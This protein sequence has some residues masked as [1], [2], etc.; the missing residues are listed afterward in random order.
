MSDIVK[1]LAR[2]P[3]ERREE[4]LALLREELGGGELRLEPRERTGPVPLSFSQ[5]T[6]WFLDR[7][8]PGRPTYNVPFASRIRGPLDVA[9]LGNSLRALV[10]RHESLRTSFREDADGPVQVVEDEVAVELPVVAVPG[11]DPSARLARARE[12]AGEQARGPFDLTRPPLWRARLLRVDDDDHLLLLTVHHIVYDGWSLGVM[13][14]ELAEGY[15]ARVEGTGPVLPALPVQYSDYALWQREWL[16][17]DRLDELTAWW[18]DRLGGAP[19]L[20]L[21]TDRARP[22]RLTFDGRFVRRRVPVEASDALHALARREGVTPFT[23]FVAVFAVLMHR[24]SG[25]D[26]VVIGSPA[27][28]R[29]R[30]EI[31]PLIGFFINMLVLRVDLSGDPSFRELLARA[32]TVVQDAFAHG[33]LPFEKLVETVR[34]VRDPSRSPLFGV[35]F[36]FQNA[37]G[38]PLSLPGLAVEQDFSELGT[39]RFDMSFNVFH[40]PDGMEFNVEFNT[41]LWDA[42]SVEQMITSMV[43]LMR[44]ATGDPDRPVSRLAL[45]PPE[46]RADQVRLGSGPTRPVPRA[47][48]GELFERRAAERPDA[49]A[50]VAGHERLTYAEL[51]ARANR[52]AHRLRAAGVGRDDRVA[53]CLPRCA[54]LTVAILGTLKAGAGYL[55]L[56]PAYPPARLAFLLSDAAPRVVLT[57]AALLDRLPPAGERLVLQLD[58]AAAELAALPDTPPPP[59]ATPAD[60]AYVIYTSGSTGTPKGVEV[61]H[62]SVVGFVVAMQELFELC[63]DDVVLG[64]ASVNFDVSVFET[65]GALLSGA[66]LLLAGD[67]ERLDPARLGGLMEHGGVTVTDLPPTVMALLEPERFRAHRIAFVGGEAFS[68]GLTTR[69]SRGGRRFFNGYGPTECTVTMVVYECIGSWDSS[70]PIGRPIANHVAH[71]VDRHLEPVPP[72]VPGELVIGGE[73]LARGYLGR[74]V[75]TT[76]RFVADPFGTASDGRLYRTGDLVKRR[77]DGE[78]VFLGRLDDQVKI[79][80]LRIE[81]GEIESVLSA[82]PA[83]GQAAA[84]PWDDERGERHLVGY[85]APGAGRELPGVPEL[86]AYLAERLPVYMVPAFVV[87]LPALPLTGSGKLDRR[88]LPAPDPARGVGTGGTAEP[89]TDTERAVAVEVFA[90]VLGLDRVGV[91]DNFFELGGNSLQAARLMSRIRERF[92]VEVGLADFFSAPTVAT[93]AAAVDKQLAARLSDDDLLAMLESMSEDEVGRLMGEP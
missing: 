70:P 24:L 1:R 17:G 52:L 41:D 80:G 91:Q 57:H 40:H 54:D 79:R 34:P 32:G 2:L 21:P 73:G 75:L 10:A 66:R 11:V 67:D 12:L 47:T 68:G 49:V 92:A 55:P 58:E 43:E 69:W 15:R 89:R 19:T 39:S 86:R 33:E 42:A 4:F 44:S 46:Q 6:L 22:A 38:P 88:A 84:Q 3:K 61:E 23:A 25:Q 8:A 14:A 56:D 62:H 28:N 45:L 35:A 16:Q 48:V 13:T 90:P 59:V 87:E 53:L 78:I 64:F 82:H 9:A 18:R 76:E 7:L 63:P 83:V 29:S 20:E 74:P 81:L 71:V 50:L 30:S 36:A 51:D 85:V 26:D 77:A 27:A 60:L 37:G 72:G 93:L 31:E 5:E 65:F